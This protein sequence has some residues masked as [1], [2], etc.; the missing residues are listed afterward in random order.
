ML[1]TGFLGALSLSC[2]NPFCGYTGMPYKLLLQETFRQTY[3]EGATT[4]WERWNGIGN[5]SFQN[6]GMNPLTIMH[7]VLLAT[8]CKRGAGEN[9][10]S[11][12]R[13]TNISF[14]SQT[15]RWPYT[16]PECHLSK[17]LYGVIQ[18]QLDDQDGKLFA[19]YYDAPT[20]PVLL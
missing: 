12:S 7:M 6:T 20:I 2:I 19:G 18:K 13:V 1:T 17:S 15:R 16:P 8:G 14:C 10:V 4:I 11:S 9:P 5:G 3:E